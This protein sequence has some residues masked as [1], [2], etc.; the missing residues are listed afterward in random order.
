G[1]LVAGL[2]LER[3]LGELL[4][5]GAVALDRLHL[6]QIREE[7]HRVGRLRLPLGEELFG[8]WTAARS[9]EEQRVGA[10]GGLE[11]GVRRVRRA[12]RVERALRIAEALE[13]AAE[14][15]LGARRRGRLRR[16]IVER[17]TRTLQVSR[18]PRLKAAVIGRLG[19]TREVVPG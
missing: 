19:G 15:A 6:S 12:V 11:P 7:S 10:D 3:L 4:T 8:V 1:V 2:L 14:R 16:G 5:T 17:G 9:R 13:D 18:H